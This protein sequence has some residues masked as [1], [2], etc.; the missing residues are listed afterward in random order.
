MPDGVY[1]AW[2]TKPLPSNHE[3]LNASKRR[4]HPFFWVCI[5]SFA[6]VAIAT[7]FSGFCTRGE[8]RRK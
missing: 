4:R 2:G 6:A 3:E 8:R 5:L 1:T 7:I